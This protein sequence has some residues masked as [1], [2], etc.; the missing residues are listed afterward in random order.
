MKGGQVVPS[1][2]DGTTYVISVGIPTRNHDITDEPYAAVRNTEGHLYQYMQINGTVLTYK[3]V[4]FENKV[5]DSF[6][7]K[8]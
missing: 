2:T 7:I 8:K 3:A 5:I 6:S 4:N 1:Y